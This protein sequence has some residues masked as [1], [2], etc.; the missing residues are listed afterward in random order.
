MADKVSTIFEGL[1]VPLSL[2][3]YSAEYQ[4]LLQSLVEEQEASWVLPE[5]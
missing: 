1:T 3:T 4:Q 5:E 2:T